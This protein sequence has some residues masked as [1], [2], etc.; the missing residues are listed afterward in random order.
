MQFVPMFEKATLFS[1]VFIFIVFGMVGIKYFNFLEA[2]N[3]V[4]KTSINHQQ[5]LINNSL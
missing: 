1:A 2:K 4:T 3:K 5:L